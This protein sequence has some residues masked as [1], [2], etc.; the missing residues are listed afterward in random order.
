MNESIFDAQE[1]MEVKSSADD[2]AKQK[3]TTRKQANKKYQGRL[4]KIPEEI[5]VISD[6]PY[7]LAMDFY[8][9]KLLDRI[10]ISIACVLPYTFRKMSP[11]TDLPDTISVE[12]GQN[13]RNVLVGMGMEPLASNINCFAPC[14]LDLL[15]TLY[16]QKKQPEQETIYIY[17]PELLKRVHPYHYSLDEVQKLVNM[18]VNFGCLYGVIKEKNQYTLYRVLSLYDYDEKY[19]VLTLRSPYIEAVIKMYHAKVH[20]DDRHSLTLPTGIACSGKARTIHPKNKKSDNS[21]DDEFDNNEDNKSDNKRG[22][23]IIE[24]YR[25]LKLLLVQCGKR[26]P[27]NISMKTLKKR[28][29]WLAEQFDRET[30]CEAMYDILKKTWKLLGYKP[31]TIKKSSSS[32]IAAAP[33]DKQSIALLKDLVFKDFQPINNTNSDG[34]S[35]NE[36]GIE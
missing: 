5:Q 17:V 7:H 4:C 21:K 2:R 6:R 16:M 19:H 11:P 35:K 31:A 14:Y 27:S 24:N 1:E 23:A 18:I 9:E 36:S 26:R 33:E 20:P 32:K 30:K 15:C 10:T 12:Q 25:I 29:Y 28:N 8:D 13:V 34:L 22:Y 3:R